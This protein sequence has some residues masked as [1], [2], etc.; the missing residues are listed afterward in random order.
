[1]K[2]IIYLVL[3]I[4]FVAV[5]PVILCFFNF[6]SWKTSG[7]I[8]ISLGGVIALFLVFYV[9][10]KTLLDR[11]IAQLRDMATQHLAD[12][13]VETD[14][15]K[16]LALESSIQMERTIE[17]ILNFILPGILFVGFFIICRAIESDLATLSTTIA[18]IGASELVGMIFSVL[19]A[20]IV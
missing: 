9:T 19:S 5:F 15:A 20:R 1:M 6:T 7:F 4:L 17:L 13:K 8:Q 3:E 11:Y 14:E 16:R 12:Y 18:I 10:K 2:K